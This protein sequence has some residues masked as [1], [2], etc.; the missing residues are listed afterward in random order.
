MKHFRTKE[1]EGVKA[2]EPIALTEAGFLAAFSTRLGGVSPLPK[3]DLNLGYFAKDQPEN[4]QENRRRFFAAVE[5]KRSNGINYKIVTAKQV[6]SA[7]NHIVN[8]PDQFRTN[9]AVCDAL[10]TDREDTLI[11]IQTADCLPVL[12]VDTQKRAVAG[13][14]AGWRGTL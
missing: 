4:V 5:A 3:G 10:L 12:I 1:F 14:H 13:I 8:D 7:D 9:P 6:H 2:I 11:G